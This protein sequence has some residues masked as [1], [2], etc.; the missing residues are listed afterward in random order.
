MTGAMAALCTPCIQA[1][2]SYFNE[3]NELL[4]SFAKKFPAKEVYSTMNEKNNKIRSTNDE[5]MVNENVIRRE[6]RQTEQKDKIIKLRKVDNKE[7]ERLIRNFKK[8]IQ[9]R[10]SEIRRNKKTINE[11]NLIIRQDEK[12][13]QEKD[14]II[15]EKEHRIHRDE[16]IIEEKDHKIKEIDHRIKIDERIIEE[17]NHLLSLL[18]NKYD[19]KDFIIKHKDHL[20]K[21]DAKV[22]EEKEDII[23]RAEQKVGQGN[24]G[25]PELNEALEAS[26]KKLFEIEENFVKDLTGQGVLEKLDSLDKV[27]LKL[28]EYNFFTLF[29]GL[30]MVDSCLSILL[31]RSPYNFSES[32][33]T[34]LAEILRQLHFLTHFNGAKPESGKDFHGMISDLNKFVHHFKSGNYSR[35]TELAKLIA[36]LDQLK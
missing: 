13:I 16:K 29:K 8:K 12:I 28:S 2:D 26:Q 3:F 7:Q 21:N 10:D 30:S 27:C 35:Q 4:S 24:D 15:R 34:N 25:H 6:K 17:K 31:S 18:E 1:S 5:S 14:H 20:I 11:Q 33:L 23:K 22:I 9:E 32:N 36:A 19:E